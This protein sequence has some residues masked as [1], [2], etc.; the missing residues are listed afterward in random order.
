MN[1]LRGIAAMLAATI[2]WGGGFTAQN[3][4]MEFVDP[5]Y[6]IFLRSLIGTAALALTAV[7]FD[8]LQGRKISVFGDGISAEEKKYLLAG[9]FWCGLAIC[10]ATIFQ[11]YGAKYTSAGKTGFLTVLYIVIVPVL[12]IFFRRK[13]NLLM[14]FSTLLALAGTYWLCGGAEFAGVG[15]CLV[16]ACAFF[17]SIHILV[18]DRYAGKCDCVRLSCLQFAVLTVISG[19]LS[20]IFRDEWTVSGALDSAWCW[21][22]CG[23][24]SSGAAFTLQMFAQK[25]LH[26]VTASLLMSL[27]SVFAVLGGWIFLQERMSVSE[28]C[29]CGMIFLAIVISQLPLPVK[30]LDGKS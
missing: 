1:K 22:F 18:I 27:E 11:Q 14:L 26:P 19:I 25:H 9:G 30:K 15:E 10:S 16:I 13:S 8:C 6:F 4:A 7:L 29:G 17:Y 12:G 3:Q 24:C 21:L 5:L 28:L 2:L 23:I 20:L